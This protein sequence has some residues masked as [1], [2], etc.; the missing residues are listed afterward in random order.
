MNADE[1]VFLA[2]WKRCVVYSME[3][4]SDGAVCR[5]WCPFGVSAFVRVRPRPNLPGVRVQNYGRADVP[6]GVRASVQA[7]RKSSQGYLAAS[8]SSMSMPRPG[9][10]L[11]YK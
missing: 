9:L 4:P 5:R 8:A 11:G 6:S 10:S 7:S 2:G 3:R 1:G